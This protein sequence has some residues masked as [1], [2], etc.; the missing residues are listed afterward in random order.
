MKRRKITA[1]IGAAML[2]MSACGVKEEKSMKEAAALQE[3]R[4][5]EG[6][7]KDGMQ[8]DMKDSKMKE[9]MRNMEKTDRKEDMDAKTESS[10]MMSK[11]MEDGTEN[12]EMMNKSMEN[13]TENKAMM[14]R[15]MEGKTAP[16]EG[17]ATR[18]KMEKEMKK[19]KEMPAEKMEKGMEKEGRMEEEMPKDGKRKD[20]MGMKSE[21]K[22]MNEGSS[23]VD[24]ALKDKDGEEFVLSKQKGKKVYVKFWASWCSICLSGLEELNAL[25]GEEKDFEVVTVVA[26]GFGAEKS[27]EDFVQWFD[28][29]E[30][31]N[32]RVLFD[33]SG[34]TM[35]SYGIRAYPTSAIVGSD[36]VMT[37]L[38]PG[39][40]QSDGI[41]GVMEE[42]H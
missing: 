22:R 20:S 24:F 7:E 12:E 11:G 5:E 1:V 8:E 27:R 34:E 42:I 32:I 23:A 3:K 30:Y 21:E 6:M 29:L 2:L 40:L 25:A 41:K 18:G 31:S 14:N 39:H 26:P 36:G 35:R 4:M 9:S 15:A 33:E 10:E 28:S 13:K 19:E 38:V 17:K 37:H 16:K